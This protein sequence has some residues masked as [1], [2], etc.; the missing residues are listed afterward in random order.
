[1]LAGSY[2]DRSDQRQS[3]GVIAMGRDHADRVE[4][5]VFAAL[6][7]APDRDQLGALFVTMRDEPYFFKNIERV[8]GD[9]SDN[10]ILTVGYG[11]SRDGRLRYMWGPLLGEYG[12]NRLNVAISRSRAHMTLVTSSLPTSS[13][14]QAPRPPA[15]S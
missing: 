15:T 13:Q 4:K 7:V 11:A 1:M 12:V 14:K 3:L 8:Q 9:E 6:E 5:A 2:C 10:I